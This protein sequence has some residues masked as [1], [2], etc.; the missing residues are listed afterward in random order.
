MDPEELASALI[1]LTEWAQEHAPQ[2]E[3]PVRRR[4]R[5]HLG[6]EP[7]E[8]P[9]VT[10]GLEAWDRPNFQ[11]AINQWAA[12]RDVEVVGLP[13]MQGYRAGLADSCGDPSGWPS[14]SS[15]R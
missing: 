6:R 7:A 12:G 10:R 3:P 11:V 15:A 8:L 2:P 14:S 13:V 5:E 9:I 4:L 1:Q